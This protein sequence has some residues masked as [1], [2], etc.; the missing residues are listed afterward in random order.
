MPIGLVL[1]L[2]ANFLTLGFCPSEAKAVFQ[3]T[4]H[5]IEKRQDAA[6]SKTSIAIV[7]LLWSRS[8]TKPQQEFSF[9]PATIDGLLEQE[10]DAFILRKQEKERALR[11]R[12]LLETRDE[13][14]LSL[15]Q[16]PKKTPFKGPK[17]TSNE[18]SANRKRAVY[19]LD[20]TSATATLKGIELSTSGNQPPPTPPPHSYK[21]NLPQDV[22]VIDDEDKEDNED[23]DDEVQV[24]ESVK[25]K[26]SS[27]IIDIESVDSY[28]S[29]ILDVVIEHPD[30]ANS[31]NS[32][33]YISLART[34][35]LDLVSDAD[36]RRIT[37]Q[38]SL[39]SSSSWAEPLERDSARGTLT[40][41][42]GLTWWTPAIQNSCNIDNFITYLC[43]RNTRQPGF[44]QRY[45]L[46]NTQAEE[47]LIRI[48]SAFAIDS[49]R[50]ASSSSNIKSIWLENLPHIVPRG[51][52]TNLV[53]SENV[54]ILFP[55]RRSSRVVQ[56]SVCQCSDKVYPQ[57]PRVRILANSIIAISNVNQIQTFARN[58]GP[59]VESGHWVRFP[60]S[61]KC[62]EC[63]QPQEF[64]F[65]FCSEATWFVHFDVDTYEMI[66]PQALPQI[67][68][69]NVIE[70]PGQVAQFDLGL[71]TLTNEIAPPTR[72]TSNNIMHATSLQ[73][74]GNNWYYYDDMQNVGRLVL[75]E[76]DLLQFIS[77]LNCKISSVDY[78]RR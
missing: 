54:N 15:Q 26:A 57:Q 74:F 53:G 10:S 59:T 68:T 61:A 41:I 6:S 40:R 4:A 17:I 1:V 64:L 27:C 31:P 39:L 58:V 55:L 35:F 38:E 43:I 25:R 69:L 16:C 65:T 3:D 72:A 48:F 62:S 12:P 23:D 60:G 50:T 63:R 5:R 45:F 44:A 37:F 32:G 22:I 18:K 21:K 8:S 28:S 42:H 14:F 20:T 30:L 34:A 70:R 76:S 19:I 47:R 46:L 33:R 73:R 78:F 7:G 52:I 71:I 49:G 66:D 75:V 24:I 51:G 29:S 67:L 2:F 77:T 9:R 56:I 36:T 11:W 13:A